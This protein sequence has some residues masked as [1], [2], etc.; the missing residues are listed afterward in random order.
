MTSRISPSL[1]ALPSLFLIACGGGGGSGSS[2]GP[3]AVA[4]S[5]TTQPA[6]QKVVLGQSA[7]FTVIAIGTPPL[8]FK[9]QKGGVP[10]SGASGS[11]YTTAATAQADDGSAFLVVVSNA[12]GSITSASAKLTVVS[13]TTMPRG[14]DVT[15]YKMT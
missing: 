5:I 13:G 8:T 11:N 3:A 2:A 10:I 14:T 7:T 9:W 6:D 1:A 15:T 12:V 4:P